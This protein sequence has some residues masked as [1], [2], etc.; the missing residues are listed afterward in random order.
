MHS[1]SEFRPGQADRGVTARTW[2]LLLLTALMVLP[3][4]CGK[5]RIKEI[6][7]ELIGVWKTSYEGY[8]G[9]HM[10]F[11]TEFLIIGTVENTTIHYLL[12]GFVMEE[13]EDRTGIKI[14]YKDAEGNE[15]SME[16]AYTADDGG[17][18]R[19][20]HQLSVVWKKEP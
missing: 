13:A 10:E 5:R 16:M 9:A 4:G 19:D 3:T 20:M 17:S 18:L 1:Q 6:P 12:T 15:M 11:T 8:A 7:V 2:L 14:Y